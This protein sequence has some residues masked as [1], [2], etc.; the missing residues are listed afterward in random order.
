MET[1]PRSVI[2]KRGNGAW[3]I[4]PDIVVK[5]MRLKF[6]NEVELIADGSSIIIRLTKPKRFHKTG[7]MK[8]RRPR[9]WMGHQQFE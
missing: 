3:L 4:L 8:L 9:P 1:K 2:R 7:R 6:G 5:E